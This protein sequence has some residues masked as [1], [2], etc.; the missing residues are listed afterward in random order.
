MPRERHWRLY[1]NFIRLGVSKATTSSVSSQQKLWILGVVVGG[2]PRSRGGRRRHSLLA[3]NME[4]RRI[5]PGTNACLRPC[6]RRSSAEPAM[7]P[8]GNPRPPLWP[9]ACGICALK[10]DP[11]ERPRRLGEIGGY[12]VFGLVADWYNSVI[13]TQASGS[14]VVCGGLIWRARGPM[15]GCKGRDVLWYRPLPS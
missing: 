9:P 12:P 5:K 13:A 10:D 3:W 15:G 2:T 4:R 6:R 11:L 7:A 8:Y 14:W 1:S